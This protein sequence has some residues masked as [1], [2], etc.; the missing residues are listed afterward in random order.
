VDYKTS[1]HE[2]AGLESFLDREQ[3]RYSP[4]LTRYAAL[5]RRLGAE[6]VRLGLYFPLLSAWR[7]W[8]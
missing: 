1:S 4:Q 2:G 3:Q 5:V 6:P 8:S 7:D